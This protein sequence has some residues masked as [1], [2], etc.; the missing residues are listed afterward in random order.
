MVLET[1]IKSGWLLQEIVRSQPIRMYY[2]DAQPYICIGRE[3]IVRTGARF[4]ELS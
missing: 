3:A 2:D 1:S 4:S